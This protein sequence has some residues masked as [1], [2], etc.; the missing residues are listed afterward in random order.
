MLI[1]D[2]I[3][4]IELHKTGCTHTRRIITEM[5]AGEYKMVGKHNTYDSV[6]A[7]LL[8][9]FEQK[10]KVGNIRNPWDWYVS[11]WA[12]GCQNH[13]GLYSRLT[14]RRT[15]LSKQKVKHLVKRGLG[16]EHARLDPA[17]W[18]EL[19]SDVN[20]HANFNAWLRLVLSPDKHDIGEGYKSK[21]ISKFAGL[22]TYRYLKLYTYRNHLANIESREGIREYDAAENFMDL[23][24]RNGHVNEGIIRLASKVGYDLDE[25][26]RILHRYRGRTNQSHR[27]RDYRPYY[28]D[29][30]VDLVAAYDSY[31]IDK[32]GY[33]FE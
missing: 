9:D 25:V 6:P 13:G 14:E 2:P 10:L 7:R 23:V 31:L 28:S 22:L 16:K 26:E 8:G 15:H 5:F 19:Y 4:Y 17:I 18:R 12:F 33:R 32:Y 3:I 11:L 30:S 24:I 20:N 21:K 27:V 1:T 29:E